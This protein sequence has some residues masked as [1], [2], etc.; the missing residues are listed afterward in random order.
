[1]KR[2]ILGALLV[3]GT[4]LMF[5]G[6]ASSA[7]TRAQFCGRWNTVCTKTCLPKETCRPSCTERLGTCRSS[8]CYFFKSPLGQQCPPARTPTCSEVFQFCKNLGQNLDCEGARANCIKT[9]RWI[10][11]GQLDYGPALKK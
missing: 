10:G 1:M 9:G 6:A 11:K 5:V 8:G 3:V 4:H 2:L 7:E